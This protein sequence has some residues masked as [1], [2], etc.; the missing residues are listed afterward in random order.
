M[1]ARAQFWLLQLLGWSAFVLALLF[2]WL[3]ALP[4]QRMLIAK[5]PLVVAGIAVTVL[6]RALYR[7]LLKRGA[8]GWSLAAIVALASYAAAIAWSSSADLISRSVLHDAEHSSLIRLSFDR[9]GGTWYCALVLAAWSMLYL[10]V[11][12]FRALASERERRVRSELLAREAKLEA[13]RYQVNPHFLFN[14][15]NAISTLVLEVRTSEAA[16]MISR[17]GDFLRLT[18]AG[19]GEAEI[20]LADEVRFMREYL[21]I[22][23]VRFGERLAVAIDVDTELE[24]LRVP[25][26]ILLPLVENAV[27]HA[28]ERNERGGR[29]SIHA[30]CAD[31]SLHLTVSDDG[32]GVSSIPIPGAGIGLANTRARLQQLFGAR[33]ALRWSTLPNGG[34]RYVIELPAQCAPPARRA[35]AVA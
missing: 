17:L 15:L 22:E 26:L 35:L 1:S 19:E 7:A 30:S 4:L 28:V 34:S 11:T 31:A 33:Q 27:R 18:L 5:A 10:G 9:F 2:P 25:A 24:S 12:Q 3:G 13:L 29:I 6:L 14:T 8:H 20:P 16:G 21:E 23:R 32:P